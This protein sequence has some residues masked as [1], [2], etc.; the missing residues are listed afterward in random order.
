MLHLWCLLHLWPNVITLATFITSIDDS[1]SPSSRVYGNFLSS[2]GNSKSS[3]GDCERGVQDPKAHLGNHSETG[4]EQTGVAILCYCPTCL[5]AFMGLSEWVSEWVTFITFVN[6][7]YTCAFNR[8]ALKEK[9]GL[10][11][12]LPWK[13]GGLIWE[14]GLIEDLR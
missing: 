3:W 2:V 14:G 6:S 11:I 13:G 9:G 1:R 4:P 10:L 7:Y 12:F 5:T 8:E